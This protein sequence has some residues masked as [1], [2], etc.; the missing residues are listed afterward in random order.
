MNV[1]DE[2]NRV[3]HSARTLV[4]IAANE[5]VTVRKEYGPLIFI[6]VRVT[7]D[8]ASGEWIIERNDAADGDGWR[9]VA[10]VPGQL[11]SDFTD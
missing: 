1:Y 10:R 11:D 8:F 5:P 9:E 4:E 6:D 7:A 2:N 3:V